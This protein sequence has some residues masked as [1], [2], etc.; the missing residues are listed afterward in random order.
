LGYTVKNSKY[1]QTAK[2]KAARPRF[3]CRGL[4]YWGVWGHI[5]QEYMAMD[6]YRYR[7]AGEGL[8]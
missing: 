6:G 8:E 2:L 4:D 1:F 3:G 5:F 7:H